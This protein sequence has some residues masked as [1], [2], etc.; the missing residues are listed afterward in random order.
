MSFLVIIYQTKISLHTIFLGKFS[1]L[2]N[3]YT[4]LLF[5][6][7]RSLKSPV[8]LHHY[9]TNKN[10]SP[11]NFLGKFSGLRNYYILTVSLEKAQEERGPP[12]F[13][14]SCNTNIQNTHSSF[15]FPGTPYRCVP[16]QKALVINSLIL[17]RSSVGPNVR[18]YSRINFQQYR[19]WLSSLF[20]LASS[21]ALTTYV[22]LPH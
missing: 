7:K 4:F 13:I 11:H 8:G 1:G 10:F 15:S 16:S 18:W 21:C 9:L 5:L 17:T 2:R 20:C 22:F 3:F 12:W 14:I 19:F 6:S